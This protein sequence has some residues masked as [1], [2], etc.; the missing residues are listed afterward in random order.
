MRESWET[1]RFWFNFAARKSFDIDVVYWSAMQ[2]SGGGGNDES[3]AE[4]DSLVEIKMQQLKAYEEEC[5]VRFP[6]KE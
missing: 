3:R 4:M 2:G 6:S 1:G 5:H